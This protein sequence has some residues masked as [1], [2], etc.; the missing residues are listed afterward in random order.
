MWEE[1]ARFTWKCTYTINIFFAGSLQSKESKLFR[2]PKLS[3]R[4]PSIQL[5][6]A[7]SIPRLYLVYWFNIWL[8]AVV[9]L[10][11]NVICGPKKLD[12]E[13]LIT[14]L[15][16]IYLCLFKISYTFLSSIFA[17]YYG[18][19]QTI[20]RDFINHVKSLFNLYLTQK[21]LSYW[22]SWQ[23]V[24]NP[25]ILLTLLHRFCPTHLPLATFV[26]LF[27]WLNVWSGHV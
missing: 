4:I 11:C 26:A 13:G 16:Q 10:F 17:I 2:Q 15:L 25:H 21:E 22:R 9:S 24:P 18:T 19:L 12:M 14:H 5:K 23:R 8:C 20:L 3:I 1:G 6:N 27:L 7:L